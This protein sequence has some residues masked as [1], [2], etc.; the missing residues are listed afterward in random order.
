MDNHVPAITCSAQEMIFLASSLGADT[1]LGIA[2]PFVGWLTEEIE[3]TKELVQATL[4]ERNFVAI[5]PDDE[6]VMDVAVAA[7]VGTCAFPDASFVV[8]FTP[9]DGEATTRY[10]HVTE[11]LAVE[12]TAMPEPVATYRLTALENGQAAYGR[13]LEIFGLNGQR[14]VSSPGGELPEAALIQAREAA[15]KTEREKAREVLEKAGLSND[16]A[17]ALAETLSNP[18]ANGALVALAHQETAWDVSGAGILEGQNGLWRLR[19]FTRE[20][21]NWVE[22]IPCDADEARESIRRVMNRVLPERI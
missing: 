12:Q 7:L 20:G 2:D 6:I 13:I 1:L 11:R 18:V 9:A 22:L 10:L 21:E 14:A 15:A 16:V 19:P 17:A 4:A 3:E 5:Q 8:T